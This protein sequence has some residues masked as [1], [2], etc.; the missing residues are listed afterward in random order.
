MGK[1]LKKQ[2]WIAAGFDVLS[3]QGGS[4]LAA[5]PMARAM[6]TTKGS[7]YWHFAD[8]PAYHTALIDAW[9]GEAL[10][11]LS[12]AVSVD[13]SADARL[14]SFG[15]GI[16]QDARE[17]ALRQWARDKPEV[18]KALTELDGERHTYLTLLLRELGLANPDFAKALQGALVG[19]PQIKTGD[20]TAQTKA[21]DTL[22][23]T[24]LA[25]SD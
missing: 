5:E 6:G 14:R 16:L 18:A 25:L 19:L 9:R 10:N 4:A 7:F 23:D 24:V 3:Q 2:D 17:T 1:R 22:V 20:L 13:A 21:Y 11:A 8:V 12:Q 15:H